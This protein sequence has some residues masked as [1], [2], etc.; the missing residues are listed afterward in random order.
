MH[1]VERRRPVVGLVAKVHSED[2]RTSEQS[3]IVIVERED[4]PRLRRAES[5]RVEKGC[6]RSREIERVR[7]RDQR[8]LGEVRVV[9]RPVHPGFDENERSIVEAADLRGGLSIERGNGL[10]LEC[11]FRKADGVRL[12]ERLV[13]DDR[14]VA[15]KELRRPPN[16]L[17]EVRADWEVGKSGFGVR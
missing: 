9:R 3:G 6:R 17:G 16:G 10:A 13:A 5:G 8:E 2:R 11:L 1:N 7:Q 12:I 14:R 15:A 4:E